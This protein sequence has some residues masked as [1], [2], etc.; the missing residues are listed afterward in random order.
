MVIVASGIARGRTHDA[1]DDDDGGVAQHGD[2]ALTRNVPPVCSST[3]F[4]L[5]DF[6]RK[7][8][9]GLSFLI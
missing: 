2:H 5:R 6:Q 1:D 4:S 7:Q 8:T 9:N 3:I